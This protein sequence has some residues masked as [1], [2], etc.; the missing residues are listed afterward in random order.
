MPNLQTPDFRPL[1]SSLPVSPNY[2]LLLI[3][4]GS[5]TTLDKTCGYSCFVYDPQTNDQRLVYGGSN[6]GT[7]NFA[8]LMAYILALTEDTYYL[9]SYPRRVEILTDSEITCKGINKEYSRSANKILWS[10]FEHFENLG[11]AIHAN[12]TPRNENPISA[13]MDKIAGKARN[14][15]DK[16]P[17]LE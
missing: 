13:L 15:L 1:L 10:F 3:G 9:R 6:Y 17:A 5:G 2:D 11:Y 12:W 14:Q 7:N 16:F 4:D 8:E